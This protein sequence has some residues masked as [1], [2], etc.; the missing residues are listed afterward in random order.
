VALIDAS[1]KVRLEIPF[2]PG[3]WFLVRELGWKELQDVRDAKARASLAKVRDLGPELVESFT[4]LERGEGSASEQDEL[5]KARA[6]HAG[7]AAQFDKELLL[8]RSVEDWSYEEKFMKAKLDRLDERT[9]DWLFGAIASLY[10]PASESEAD[11]GNAFTPS[12][13]S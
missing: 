2:E 12:T 13:A 4:A 5:A 8:S 9:S 1:P 11:R 6:Q 10:D 3:E 7:V